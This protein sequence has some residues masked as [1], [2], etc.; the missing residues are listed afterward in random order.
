M[1]TKPNSEQSHADGRFWF[2][3][4]IREPEDV[5]LYQKVNAGQKYVAP[6]IAQQVALGKL[7]LN[8]VNPFDHI[9]DRELEITMKLVQGY[10]YQRL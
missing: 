3:S 10:A 4:K 7:E 5:T 1:H 2:Y 9:S 8:N 6:E